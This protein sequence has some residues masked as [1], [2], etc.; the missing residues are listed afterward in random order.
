MVDGSC[1]LRKLLPPSSSS[2]S[3]SSRTLR[4]AFPGEKSDDVGTSNA[5]IR[6][7]IPSHTQSHIHTRHHTF[8]HHTYHHTLIYHTRLGCLPILAQPAIPKVCK[9][10]WLQ[11]HSLA[12]TVI[13]VVFLS[14]GL[15]VDVLLRYSC[16][17]V[18]VCVMLCH[19]VRWCACLC[20]PSRWIVL[21]SLSLP[22][23]S[24]AH[25]R[26]IG[27]IAPSSQDVPTDVHTRH[28]HPHNSPPWW[29][30]TCT[31]NIA[32]RAAHARVRARSLGLSHRL[33]RI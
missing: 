19:C 5:H 24:L 29:L 30:E 16:V 27:A 18:C 13:G 33:L 1:T 25:T 6:T 32:P 12:C 28:A 23:L 21:C 14:F 4:S 20:S 3:S 8:C 31:S 22:F 2:S 9:K 10:K 15:S 11:C 26:T 7:M 17:C